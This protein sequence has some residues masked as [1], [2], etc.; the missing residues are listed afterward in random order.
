MNRKHTI[1][2]LAIAAGIFALTLASG[3][4]TPARME[5]RKKLTP[6]HYEVTQEDGSSPPGSATASTSPP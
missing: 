5:L 4:D 1:P 6:I 2:L 3:K